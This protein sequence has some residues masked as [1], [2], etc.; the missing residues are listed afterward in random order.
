[1]KIPQSSWRGSV[2]ILVPFHDLDPLEICWHGHYVRYFELARTNLLQ[3]IDYDYPGM[4]ASGYAW[5][6][7]ELYIRYA[8]ALR[9]Q[10]RICVGA[11]LTE[12]ENRLKIDYLIRDA[13]SGERLTRGY[14]VQVAVDM[15]TREMC[16]ESPPVL[17]EKLRRASRPTP[18]TDRS[19]VP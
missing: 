8:R 9:Y 17:L 13:M 1:M 14:S 4:R 10:Q 2:E 18:Q 12:W 16:L 5:P 19:L 11:W 6:I 15:K 7:I 3:N